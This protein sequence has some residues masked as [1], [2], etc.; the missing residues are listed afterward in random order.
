MLMQLMSMRAVCINP[1]I[2]IVSVFDQR[3]SS[4]KASFA[5][6]GVDHCRNTVWY[7]PICKHSFTCLCSTCLYKDHH[8]F[9]PSVMPSSPNSEEPELILASKLPS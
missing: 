4:T 1:H 3:L 6:Y 2:H 7:T 8:L 9:N 5:I